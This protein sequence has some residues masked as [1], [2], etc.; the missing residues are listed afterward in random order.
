MSNKPLFLLLCGMLSFR[1]ISA[2]TNIPGG[3]VSGTWTAAGSPYNVQGNITVHADSTLNIEPGV[4]VEFQG[5]FNLTVNG[6]LE[7]VGTESDPIHFSASVS[8][9]GLNFNNAPDSSHL[10]H[11]TITGCKNGWAAGIY[12]V[13][14][15]PVITHCTIS[16]NSSPFYGGIAL[17]NSNPLIS[18]CTISNN[19]G[20]FNYGSGISMLNSSPEISYCSII[21]NGHANSNGIIYCGNGCTALISHCS[22]TGNEAIRGGG[23]FVDAGGNPEI[24]NSTISSNI[25]YN[26]GGIYFS[27]GSSGT[28]TDC[29]INA[30][31]T[32]NENNTKGGGILI[33]SSSG[34]FSISNTT[35]SNC[36]S[37]YG[38]SGI[39][40]DD[41][42]SVLI[43][44]STF[45]SNICYDNTTFEVG[46]IY[47][48]NCDSLLID[49]CDLVKNYSY[50][51][52]SGITLNGNTNLTLTNS[53]F[54]SHNDNDI[55]FASYS[56]ASV[57]YNDFYG[58]SGET[59]A[60]PPT[61]LGTLVQ[62]NA[63]GD[64]C[65]AFY[66]IY[67]DPIFVDLTN[68]DYQLTEDSPCI[69]AG[70]PA[71]TLD[72]DNTVTD[73]GANYFHQPGNNIPGGYV[74]GTWTVTYSPYLIRGDITIHADSALTI[75]PGVDVVFQGMY[76]FQVN[77]TLM[78]E[79]T[80]TDPVSFT[81]ADTV[82]GWKG[83]RLDAGA[84]STRILY[85]SIRYGR[86][87]D[88]GG[89]YCAS[90]K[91][92]I[93]HCTIA[94]NRASYRGGGICI[95]NGLTNPAPVVEH[96]VFSRNSARYGG[97]IYY[98]ADSMVI[99]DC[100]ISDNSVEYLAG[101]AFGGGIY[102]AGGFSTSVNIVN[103]TIQN[104][105]CEADQG[106]SFSGLGGGIYIHGRNRGGII[107]SDCQILGNWS[108]RAGGGVFIDGGGA[109]ILN[110]SIRGNS[111]KNCNQFIPGGIEL[112]GGAG[113][114]FFNTL[115]SSA[116]SQCEIS[117][118]TN[119]LSAYGGAGIR[120]KNSTSLTIDRCTIAKN[121]TDIGVGGI[122][123]D[124][125]YNPQPVLV[126]SNSI[127][128]FNRLGVQAENISIS[129]CNFFDNEGWDVNGFKI[130]GNLT[131]TNAN[132]DSCDVNSNTY[133]DPLFADTTKS[134]YRL[135]WSNWPVWD[136]TRSPAIDAGDTTYTYDPDSTIIDMGRYYF[137]QRRPLLFVSDTFLNFNTVFIGNQADL[138]FTIYNTGS[139]TL[140]LYT[141]FSGSTVFTTNW[142]PSENLIL[143]GDSLEITVYFEPDDAIP[144]TDTL[145]IENNHRLS[146][147]LLTGNG[148]IL[149]MPAIALSDT[150]MDFGTVIIG[151]SEES[152]ITLYNNGTDTLAIYSLFND[153]VVFASDYNQGDSLV[154][155]GDSLTITITFTPDAS[156]TYDDTLFIGNNDRQ[157]HIRLTGKGQLP[158]F[159]IISLS[160][161]VLYFGTVPVSQYADLDITIYNIGT[162]NLVIDSITSHQESF[163]TDYIPADSLILPGDSLTVTITYTPGEAGA[164]IDTIFI[165]SNDRDRIIQLNGVGQPATGIHDAPG[166]LPG[167]YALMPAY[168]NPFNSSTTFV[169]DLPAPGYVTFTVY[170][171]LGEQVCTLISENMNAGRHR[172]TWNPDGLPGGV[173]FCRFQADQCSIIRKISFTR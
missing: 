142:D 34:V 48:A 165:A 2:E 18:N 38:G 25:A 108:R 76:V 86:N 121:F 95:L 59:F 103:C 71:S 145:Q 158:S 14:S 119:G 149:T 168:P 47:S 6:Y 42:L 10:T 17:D 131:G 45:H 163:S 172:V 67:L 79:G 82:T 161:T 171:I 64:S 1:L 77:G 160:D 159:P 56:S 23:I 91:T 105:F 170:N 155:A 139:D 150:I 7:A 87:T 57:S 9:T 29:I 36:W 70:D 89:I 15:N 92:V 39:H 46:A 130:S 120:I 122:K 148:E 100:L 13:N 58:S 94:D 68:G 129:F 140:E 41:A 61:G 19:K 12:C 5:A 113:I 126:L 162:G 106:S 84:D 157:V 146:S 54:R 32:T 75:E 107:I 73:M 22:I 20:F 164:I 62:T 110:S 101:D 66:N 69:D 83:I 138:P 74:S 114:C 137:N 16:N 167:E 50:W 111:T 96:C 173:Y 72:P 102:F 93:T 28:I 147:V 99:S 124:N 125:E 30:D 112:T 51:F 151:H 153:H 97:G 143:P 37:R 53:I 21:G 128:A 118:N 52:A 135:T 134:D 154:L 31:S 132:G 78:A 104:N 88:G 43:T 116:V 60:L 156:L 166:L 85:A 144:F 136:S 35:I 81:A 152:T 49:H 33:S 109:R 11:C 90:P 80:E 3:Y 169:F 26:G 63:N 117:E 123:A 133:S 40:I 44:G 127:I 65:D 4:E 141:L 8:W 27:N 98:V 115:D 24:N 55:T